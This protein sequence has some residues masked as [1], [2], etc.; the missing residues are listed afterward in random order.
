MKQLLRIVLLVACLCLCAGHVRAVETR[1][2]GE[3][4]AATTGEPLPNV[5]VYF[6]GSQVG[7]T[8]D[9]SGMFYLHVDLLR[10]ATLTVSSIGYKTQRFT[11]EPGQDAGLAVV[12]EE[13]RNA[14][15]ELVVLPGANPALP[16]MDSVRAHRLQNMPPEGTIGGQT[17][18]EYFISQITAKTLKRRLWR[19][20]QSGMI[21]QEDSTYIL[22]V[23]PSLSATLS[24]PV[25]EHM[26]FY[27]PTVPFGSL[28]L[29]SPTAAS[30]PAYYHFFLI[31]SLTA[32]KR[33][34]VDFRPKNA[35]DPLFTGTL[36]IDS[37][38][39][40][41]T[42]VEA[43]IPREANINFLSSLHYGSRYDANRLAEEQ[44][45]AVLDLAVRTD[46]S[47][48][49]PSLLVKQTFHP[50]P[51]QE[52]DSTQTLPTAPRA[53]F[54]PQTLTSDSTDLPLFRVAS[55]V[56]WLVHTGYARTGTPVDIGNVIELLQFN[57]YEK[58]HIGL[59]FRTNER[60]FK[61]VSLEG[62]VGYGIRDRGIKYKAQMQV[63]MPTER[64]N[65]FGVSWWDHYVYSEV[66]PFD[67]LMRENSWVYGNMQL[68]SYLL[69][70]VFYKGSQA[71][72][73]AVRKQELKVWV[74]NDWCSSQ[75]A[76]PSVETR[77]AVHAGRMGY[78]NAVNYHYY[79]M[80]SFRHNSVAATVRL[81]WGE[82]VVDLYLTRK[83]FQTGYP[84]VFLGAE[85]GSWMM[86]GE[87]HYHVY[88]NLNVLVK[89]TA[90]LGM[91]GT[92]TY[93][94][95][96][97][98]ILGKVP[99]PL[100]ASPN[101]NQSYT[102]A[103]ERF[104]LMNNNQYTTDKFIQLHV[105][106]NGQGILFNRIPGVRYLRLR[107]LVEMKLAYGGLSAENRQLNAGLEGAPM[108]TLTIPYLEAGVGIGNILRVGEVYSVWRITPASTA[109]DHY[110]SLPRWAIRFRFNLGL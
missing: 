1:I 41:I 50:L 2:I 103:A 87:R 63:I 80:P 89:H 31:D 70:D 101:G 108:S 45:R 39:Y 105:N 3:V 13:K 54:A 92:L 43:S 16:L 77:L 98:I 12:L 91:G 57:R 19:S 24:V 62:Y 90:S 65:I 36:T 61:H 99:Y 56:G 52:T 46:S 53:H 18:Q 10:T 58:V 107:E 73:S 4:F 86:D 64:R 20:L 71:R 49:F 21:L 38:T 28:S 78:G 95:R 69:S 9:Q 84:T 51:I 55:W 85:M 6:K 44:M 14:L 37:A 83:H 34:L 76:R 23:P 97:G 42:E 60:L 67:E 7:T 29:L 8:T 109:T 30:A 96:A 32:P 68:M 106:W 26:N 93:A 82:R 47:H 35:F 102:F 72:T 88:G 59:P 94:L 11:I 33:Y 74:D 25:P 48:I 75:G 15:S 40:A 81:G 104:T 5:S 17:E 27:H 110:A 22:P 66:T 100:L 79:D